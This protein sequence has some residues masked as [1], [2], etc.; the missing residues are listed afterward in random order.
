M[1]ARS[2]GEPADPVVPADTERL[3]TEQLAAFAEAWRAKDL[4]RL[5]S[6]MTDDC[7]FRA[8]VGSE[9]GATF[10][11]R[12]EVR[13]GFAQSLAHDEGAE[14]RLGAVFVAGN[15]AAAEWSYVYPG[16]RG[17]VRGCDLFE[18]TDGKISRKDSFWKIVD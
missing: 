8:S 4:D 3:I 10:T 14:M 2:Q 11:G 12:A 17:E 1:T 13:L 5:M 16:N 7:E 9:P 18:F 15:R 6:L